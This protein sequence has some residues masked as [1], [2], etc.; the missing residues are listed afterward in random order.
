MRLRPA[1]WITA[2]IL[3]LASGYFIGRAVG[4]RDGYLDCAVKTRTILQNLEAR[5]NA[6]L[7]PPRAP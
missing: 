3:L 4:Y 6:R 1:V 7:L 5:Q 2:G